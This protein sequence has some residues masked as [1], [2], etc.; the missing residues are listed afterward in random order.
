MSSNINQIYIANPA[1][2]LASTDLFYLGR[3]PYGV[4]ND[5][6]TT[7]A[8]IMSYIPAG[9]TTNVTAA[10]QNMAANNNYIANRASLITFALPTTA[11]IGTTIEIVGVGA[12]GWLISQA[13]GQQIIIGSSA[14]TS[15]VGG[16]IASTNRYDTVKLMCTTANTVF[17]VISGVTSG[18]TIV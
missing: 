4:T 17:N 10:S 18:Y 12:G 16:S 3:S 15:G 1:T 9:T 2:T 14:S 7:W 8:T 13:L 11:A 5:M 6:A